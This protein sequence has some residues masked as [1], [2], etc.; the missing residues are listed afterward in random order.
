[1]RTIIEPFRIKS[2]EPIRR[3]T[4]AE[5]E[6]ALELAHRNLFALHTDDVLIDLLT[7]SGTGAM[8]SE[9]WAGIM[10]GDE[11]Y[12]GA[13]SFDRF[14]A[15]VRDVTGFEHVIPTHQGR[16]AEHLLFGLV[17]GSGRTIPN[18]THFDTTRANIEVQGG[19]ACDLVPP[20]YLDP[21]TMLP[22]KGDMDTDR[23]RDVIK[24]NGAARIPLVMLT[25]TNN[26]SGGQP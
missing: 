2:V 22:F 19:E 8:S 5:R 6:E 1:M 12:A 13:I 24:K 25:V 17:G 15:S 26:A 9:Q 18:N 23:L 20:E 10:R 16:A 14:Q 3:T 11:T 7:D 21:D 4:H